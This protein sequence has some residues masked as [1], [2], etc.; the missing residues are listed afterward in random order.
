ML[1]EETEDLDFDSGPSPVRR[2]GSF[3]QYESRAA[4]LAADGRPALADAMRTPLLETGSSRE[5]PTGDASE[6]AAAFNAET[7]FVGKTLVVSATA[8]APARFGG[9]PVLVRVAVGSAVG[10]EG[11]A[12]V[13]YAVGAPEPTT[14]REGDSHAYAS[15]GG[16][17]VSNDDAANPASG[18]VA[19]GERIFV[20][21]ALA[22]PAEAP[23]PGDP[24]F[25]GAEEWVEAECAVS[26]K[27]GEPA[28][29]SFLQEV[30]VKLRCRLLPPLP[31]TFAEKERAETAEKSE[32]NDHQETSST[33]H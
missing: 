20:T 2:G 33:T 9:A 22:P 17:S 5:D 8:R 26:L 3:E 32:E 12:D 18:T 10:P 15:R 30:T 16:W 28:F 13:T 4:W 19:A 27:G 24:A 21:F 7:S 11:G 25:F 6:D 29:P 14:Y 31:E 23:R 1:A